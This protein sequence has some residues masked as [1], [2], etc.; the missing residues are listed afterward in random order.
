MEISF[1]PAKR[2][3]NLVKHGLDLADAELLFR[4]DILEFPDDSMDYL[5][6]RWFAIGMLGIDVVVCIWADWHDD[7]RRVR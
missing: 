2:A 5:E 1:D 4:S 6:E 7:V 3:A